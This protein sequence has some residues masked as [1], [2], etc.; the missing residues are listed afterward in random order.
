MKIHKNKIVFGGVLLLIVLFLFGYGYTLWGEAS[1]DEP[2]AKPTL[3]RWED[4]EATFKT[5]LEAVDAI[6]P[7]REARVLPS[8]YPEHM[9]DE[10][11]Y[12]NPDYMEYEKSRI[13]DSIYARGALS[14]KSIPRLTPAEPPLSD[15]KPRTPEIPTPTP[16]IEWQKFA[17][18]HQLFFAADPNAEQPQS[19]ILARILDV[20]TVRKDSRVCVEIGQPIPWG[21]VHIESGTR[22]WGIASFG[23][24]RLF[25]TLSDLNG[26]PIEWEA[27]DLQD[28]LRGIYLENSF[29]AEAGNQVLGEVAEDIS[30]P[31]VPQLRGLKN[32]FRRRQQNPKVTLLDGHMFVFKSKSTSL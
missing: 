1:S 28:G 18:E 22:A 24:N 29:R 26:H 25:I 2:L 6:A 9:I 23:S 27:Y 17:V 12:F 21:D 16:E 32:V 14:K 30:L 13:I 20:Q 4:T 7:E 10:K 15:P 31:G 3:P 19:R 8:P 11:G 5:K